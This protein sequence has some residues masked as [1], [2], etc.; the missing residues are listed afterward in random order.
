MGKKC[1]VDDAELT[2]PVVGVHSRDVRDAQIFVGA[3][4]ASHYWYADAR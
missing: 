4:G 3:L 1:F 2:M